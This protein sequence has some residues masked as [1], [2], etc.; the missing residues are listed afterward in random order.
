V[1][2]LPSRIERVVADY[3]ARLEALEAAYTQAV[4]PHRAALHKRLRDEAGR[5]IRDIRRAGLPDEVTRRWITS[6]PAYRE[7]LAAAARDLDRVTTEAVRAIQWQIASAAE[8][9]KPA[10]DALT[11]ATLNATPTEAARL[12]SSFGQVPTGAVQQ[13]VGQLQAASPL[14][15]LPGLNAEAVEAMGR[16]LTQGLVNGTNSRVIARRLAAASDIPIARAQTIARTETHRAF[17]EANRAAMQAN[18]LVD[19]WVWHAKLE[20]RTC[21]ACWAMHG[22]RFDVTVPFSGHPN[23]RCVALPAVTPPAWMDAPSV[24][25]PTGEDAFAQLSEADR[26]RVLGP[27]KAEAYERGDITLADTVRVTESEEWGVTRSTASLKDALAS[28]S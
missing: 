28:A 27:S 26:R 15:Q 20:A 16:H 1:A 2:R 10:A 3:R 17:R 24:E 21:S 5:F 6:Q 22:E 13:L 12:A 23:C 18:P 25:Y 4:G 9:G 8:L 19:Q 14:A 11:I 7:L